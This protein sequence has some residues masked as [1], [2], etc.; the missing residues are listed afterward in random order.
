MSTESGKSRDLLTFT[1]ALVIAA[2][3]VGTGLAAY[4]ITATR[5][6][7]SYAQESSDL[8]AQV[9]SITGLVNAATQAIK[10]ATGADAVPVT[11][12]TSAVQA[13][14]NTVLPVNEPAIIPLQTAMAECQANLDQAAAYQDPRQTVIG[15]KTHSDRVPTIVTLDQVKALTTSLSDCPASLDPATVQSTWA[16]ARTTAAMMAATTDNQAARSSLQTATTA[17][18]TLLEG[19]AGKVADDTV[20]Q[21]LQTAINQAN[22][23]LSVAAPTDTYQTLDADTASIS[24]LIDPLTAASTAV[25]DA[26]VSWQKAQD[27][28]T[29]NAHRP[30]SPAGSSPHSSHQPASPKNNM[31]NSSSSHSNP[32][33]GDHPYVPPNVNEP[34]GHECM[35]WDGIP[36]DNC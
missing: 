35:Y 21:A 1:S 28:A 11:V 18:N 24:A 8:K 17:A 13:Y 32:N 30:A 9:A 10:T 36:D 20:R 19:S 14:S 29:T 15:R 23:G 7:S 4:F 34:T 31:T 2:V 5:P 25:T 27:A 6:L 22:A 26:Q 16:E 33:P 12:G 3:L